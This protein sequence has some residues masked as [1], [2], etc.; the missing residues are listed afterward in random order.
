MQHSFP[1]FWVCG[2]W[3]SFKKVG[4]Q[5]PSGLIKSTNSHFL[6]SI[7]LS[8]NT[9]NGHQAID[10]SCGFAEAD[11]VSQSRGGRVEKNNLVTLFLLNLLSIV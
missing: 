11:T 2:N 7:A 3:I 5:C 9:F 4:A 10:L 8:I 6:P 1:M